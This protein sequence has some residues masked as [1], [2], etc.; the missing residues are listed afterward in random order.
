MLELIAPHAARLPLEV[1]LRD[2]LVDGRLMLLARQ[3]YGNG[4]LAQ[5][6]KA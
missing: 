5:G 6:T 2:M 4:N 1:G 3:E